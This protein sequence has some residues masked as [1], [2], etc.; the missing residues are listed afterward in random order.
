MDAARNGANAGIVRRP[1][2]IAELAERAMQNL[3]DESKDFKYYL[4]VAE[5][6]RKEGKEFSK[7]GDLEAAFVELARAATLVLEKLPLHRDYQTML[8][9]SQ[10]QNLALNG[11]DILDNLSDIKPT[12]VD[13]YDKWLQKHPDG[14][15]QER[16]PN[17]R[18]Q[19][20]AQ[21]A[22]EKAR[23][24]EDQRR[25]AAEEAHMWKQQNELQRAQDEAEL[26]RR[27]SAAAAVRKAPDYTFSRPPN[28]YG[29]QNTVVLS[30]G[31]PDSDA[32]RRQHEQQEQMRRR[33]EEITRRQAEQK[34]RQE[35]DAHLRRKQQ[36]AEEAARAALQS[37]PQ[38]AYPENRRPSPAYHPTLIEYPSVPQSTANPYLN[39]YVPPTL[40]PLENP[41][42]F[43]GDS[44]DSE[45]V[46]RLGI[47]KADNRTPTRPFRS[48]SYPPPMTTTSP[49][50]DA[51]TI[52]YPSLMSQ[53][54]KTQGYFPS[55]GSMFVEDGNYKHHETSI[56]F[57][58]QYAGVPPP[59]AP[60]QLQHPHNNTHYPPNPTPVV[61]IPHIPIQP[62]TEKIPKPY[63]AVFDPNI[64]LKTVTLPRDCLPR[65]LA[66]AKVNTE[67]N[68]ETCGLLLGKS[69]GH[70]FVVTT[71]LI[72][73]QH[74]TSDT[75]TMDE[76][77]LVL[78]FTEERNLITLG[79]IH[80][81]P[82]QSCFMSSVDLHT[83]SG[84]QRML[85]ESFAVV[86]APKST[87]NFG[88]FRLTDPPG[89]YTI[90]NCNEK[91]AFH[92]HPDKPIYT[93]A[94]KGHVQMKDTGLEIVDLR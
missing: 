89:L 76:E 28:A 53:H 62:A 90:L 7:R 58:S 6:Y 40:M 71:L 37:Y 24:A 27:A 18:T 72:P 79:W 31:R 54:Q 25:R 34:R 41:T 94:D 2:S 4:R 82:S 17:A 35:H 9:P 69:K 63:D 51:G 55:L 33:E 47:R 64:P 77:E 23:I 42:N 45:S 70:K 46:H 83:H 86:C 52:R 56:L 29:S 60:P 67:M 84:F 48:P 93:D 88:I 66:I 10:R 92:P 5:K 1:A 15:D 68:R 11:Q 20:I 16:T 8:N 38:S 19:K 43:E 44:T 81:H 39:P 26:Q 21:E 57:G 3:Y 75:C 85:P 49:I 50:P 14:I 22:E 32:I 30:D 61:E 65:F 73:K 12:L 74:A 78:Q 59:P 80:T 36:E 87:P 91:E 13:R